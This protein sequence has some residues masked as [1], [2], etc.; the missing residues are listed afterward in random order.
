MALFKALVT[1]LNIEVY[2]TSVVHIFKY[3]FLCARCFEWF[4]QN[5]WLC[6]RLVF[7]YTEHKVTI[8]DQFIISRNQ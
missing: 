5:H 6:L 4:D 3:V 7:L 1:V 8:G 2:V